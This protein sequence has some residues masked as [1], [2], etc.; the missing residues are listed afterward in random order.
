MTHATLVA[1]TGGVGGAKLAAGLARRMPAGGLKLIV[2]TGDDFEHLGLQISPD[3]DTLI[4]T[5]ADL[6]NRETGWGRR[7]ETWRFMQAL[8]E[9]GGET[10]FQL[11]DTDLALHVERTRRLKAGESLSQITQ[12]VALKFGIGADILPMSDQRVSTRLHTDQGIL[13]FQ[14]YFV[15]LGCKPT[16]SAI[17]FDGAAAAQPGEGVIRALEDSRLQAIVICPSNPYLSIDPVLSIAGIRRRIEAAAVPVIAVSPIIGG[18]AVKGP[19][20][21][22]MGE[23]GLAPCSLEVARHY[24]GLI[25]AIVLDHADRH[26]AEQLPVPALVTNTLMRSE[27]DRERLAEECLAFASRLHNQNR[28]GS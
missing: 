10:W 9:L 14:D 12:T 26:L 23:L 18:A 7:N 1:L 13:D 4:Y 11:G 20:A 28:A 5:L 2:N 24:R 3:I 16:V 21:K 27:Q 8:G 15:R 22:I 19:T 6:V 17:R 25:D